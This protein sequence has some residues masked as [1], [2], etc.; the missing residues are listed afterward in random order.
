MRFGPQRHRR[1]QRGDEE[2]TLREREPIDKRFAPGEADRRIGGLGEAVDADEILP[3]DR[4]CEDDARVEAG[5]VEIASEERVA[6]VGDV[7]REIG[8]GA[9]EPVGIGLGDERLAG[10]EG[11]SK[12]KRTT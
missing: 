11:G 4:R 10:D 5:S 1:R 6:G 9:E 12:V 3:R 8:R 2:A 7:E